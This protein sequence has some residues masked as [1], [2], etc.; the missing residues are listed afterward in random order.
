MFCAKIC[1]FWFY[2]CSSVIFSWTS[3]GSV[4]TPR[5]TSVQKVVGSTPINFYSG[6]RNGIRLEFPPELEN[7]LPVNQGPQT[8]IS[9]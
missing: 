3:H 7:G 8:E 4:A 1:W 5:V 6:D 9:K 2:F